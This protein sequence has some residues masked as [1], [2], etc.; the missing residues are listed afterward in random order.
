MAR[1][2][3]WALG[4][5][6]PWYPGSALSLAVFEP[7]GKTG[8]ERNIYESY[9]RSEE[10]DGYNMPG[11]RRASARLA[12]SRRNKFMEMLGMFHQ[13]NPPKYLRLG[14]KDPE[15]LVLTRKLGRELDLSMW[16]TGPA[17]IVIGYL[18]GSPTPVPLR[19]DGK[20]PRSVGLTVVRW[21]HPLSGGDGAMIAEG[22]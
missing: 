22:R 4:A 13:L 18:E 6:S 1:G 17:L 16:F 9:I 3:M 20:A 11:V 5:D 15:T 7:S 19:V 8:L 2:H 14:D 21:I 10:G 12:P